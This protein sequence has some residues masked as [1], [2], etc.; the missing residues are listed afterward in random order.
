VNISFLKVFVTITADK[1]REE[2]S[3]MVFEN[4]VLKRIFEPKTQELA[5]GWRRLQSEELV[6]RIVR[7]TKYYEGYQVK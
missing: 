2:N 3:L 4:R 5:G 1:V 7:F 6:S